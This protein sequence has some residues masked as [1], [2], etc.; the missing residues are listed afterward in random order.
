MWEKLPSTAT[1]VL[2]L[3]FVCCASAFAQSSYSPEHREWEV[4]VFSGTSAGATREFPTS[5]LGSDQGLSRTVRMHYN[6]GWLLGAR[7]NQNFGDYWAAELEYSFAN[8]RLNFDGLLPGQSLAFTNYLHNVSY[9]ATF[10][11]LPRTSR[12]RP[13][14]D[15]GIG[16]GLFFIPKRSEKDALA[17]GI[18]L[19]DSWEF[20]FN[21]GGG[22]KYLVADQFAITFDVRDR[23]SRVP[24]YGL[25]ESARIINGQFQ[26]GMA[27]H[28]A[29]QIW[30]FN[31]GF[32][33]QWDE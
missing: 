25:P 29:L 32:T 12:F 26:P 27:S 30:Q 15:A 23:L 31:L 2:S 21:W 20:L 16:F 17:N 14:A 11:P 28:G 3:T 4:T 1:W 10:L 6:S 33:Y 9:N 7:A 19:R 24:S 5:V 8:Q 18:H 13:Y 22:L